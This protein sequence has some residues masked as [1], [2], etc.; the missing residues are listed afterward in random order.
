LRTS[1]FSYSP[2]SP[3]RS[4]RC[5][6]ITSVAR[7]TLPANNGT[8]SAYGMQFGIH[9]CLDTCLIPQNGKNVGQPNFILVL[10][11]LEGRVAQE[12][13]TESIA[14]QDTDERIDINRF[15]LAKRHH[16]FAERF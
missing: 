8:L 14:N 12:R 1:I 9:L 10:G 11:T 4:V 3:A 7:H 5:V 15:N 13:I 2:V 16:S 6:R